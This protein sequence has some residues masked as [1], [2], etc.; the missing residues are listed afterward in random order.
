[1]GVLR[2]HSNLVGLVPESV[3]NKA[4]DI[5]SL[6]D[7]GNARFGS[8]AAAAAASTAAWDDWAT[9][10][11][12]HLYIPPDPDN[13][14]FYFDS[15]TPPRR[16]VYGHSNLSS[17]TAASGF[18][19][20]S[21]TFFDVNETLVGTVY[22]NFSLVGGGG[23]DLCFGN[24]TE[25][26]DVPTSKV[27]VRGL[28][29]HG[30]T[31]YAVGFTGGP[32]SFLSTP[33]VGMRFEN[34]FL[35]PATSNGGW[36]SLTQACD[37]M[38]FDQL[39][40]S[41]PGGEMNNSLILING[42]INNLSFKSMFMAV[43]RDYASGS[44]ADS[45]M[46]LGSAPK[47]VDWNGSYF[48]CSPQTYA[49][50]KYFFDIESGDITIKRHWMQNTSA[51]VIFPANSAIAKIRS[52]R[53]SIKNSASAITNMDYVANMEVQSQS[54]SV[55]VELDIAGNEVAGVNKPP[56]HSSSTGIAQD[57]TDSAYVFG[58][59]AGVSYDHDYWDDG[60]T[61]SLTPRG[62]VKIDDTD[63]PYTVP[64]GKTLILADATNGAITVVL[65]Q[66][67]NGLTV[68][69]KKTDASA[70]AVTVDG[71]AA[72]TIDGAATQAIATQYALLKMVPEGQN[73]AYHVI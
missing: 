48:E 33:G 29:I 56:V 72:E 6:Y 71:D 31:E 23:V 49:K 39:R 15:L 18:T 58:T 10:S 51:G 14:G 63:S 27:Q 55:R 37:D 24:D 38:I 66:A 8:D 5:R 40:C 16:S 53:V 44:S 52:G 47:I 34:C 3:Q 4:S 35:K 21:A 69:V 61:V 41:M 68:T 1:M 28:S 11:E 54:G 7:F 2:S 26:K 45:I 13:V 32:G 25:T 12:E 36:I 50:L 20:F 59:H 42:S 73:G 9:N 67:A 46:K 62:M 30:G 22:E 19:P 57:A 64:Y 65:P 43:I 70:N 60:T 17:L